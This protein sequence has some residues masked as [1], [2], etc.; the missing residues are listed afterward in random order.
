M[1]SDSEEVSSIQE[2]E[3]DNKDL[4]G[5]EFSEDS[6]E[7]EN[8]SKDNILNGLKDI[9]ITKKK[10]NFKSIDDILSNVKKL[11]SK[12]NLFQLADLFGLFDNFTKDYILNNND[13]KEIENN[14]KSLMDFFIGLDSNDLTWNIKYMKVYQIAE[15][16]LAIEINLIENPIRGRKGPPCPKCKDTDTVAM[17]TQTR[18]G[19]EALSS[20]NTCKNCK[21]TWW[22]KS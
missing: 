19:D 9:L 6:E 1:S 2:S 16:N 17:I 10:Y 18:S 21:F 8:N 20:F 3:E 22:I 4:S 12:K 7:L 15:K 11:I 14:Y 13:E 5:E